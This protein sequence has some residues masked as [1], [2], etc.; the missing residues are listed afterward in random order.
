MTDIS[1]Q[2]RLFIWYGQLVL[3][4]AH[5]GTWLGGIPDISSIPMDLPSIFYTIDY[6][7]SS[8]TGEW[9]IV[10]CGDGQVSDCGNEYDAQ[11]LYNVLLGV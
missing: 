6:A 11:V 7:L 5:D 1:E 3:A 10:E 8:T 9:F 4:T 2:V